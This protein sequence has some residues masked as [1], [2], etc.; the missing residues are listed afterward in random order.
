M[1]DRPTELNEKQ[2]ALLADLSLVNKKFKYLSEAKAEV[3]AKI[4]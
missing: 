4:V 3:N 2:Q 1:P